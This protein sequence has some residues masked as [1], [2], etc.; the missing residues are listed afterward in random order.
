MHKE[1]YQYFLLHRELQLPGIGTFLLERQPAEI[2]IANR[3][4]SPPVYS[5]ALHHGNVSSSRGLY[6]WLASVHKIGEADAVVRFNDFVYKTRSSILAGEQLD[7]SGLG[8]LSK[9]LAGEIRFEPATVL[10][11]A[12]ALPATK[13]LRENAEHVVRVGEREMS[14]GS[15]VGRFQSETVTRNRSWILVLLLIIAAICFIGYYFSE[16]G[17]LTT[18]AGSRKIIRPVEP[19]APSKTIP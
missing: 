10:R 2:D 15:V 5:V 18:S 19:S 6:Q 14:A 12:E 8:T 16:H 4:V 17:V 3:E 9:G 1:L 7:W 13:V 11:H